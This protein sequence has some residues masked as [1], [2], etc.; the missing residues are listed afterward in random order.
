MNKTESDLDFKLVTL[1]EKHKD[2]LKKYRELEK[3]LDNA[4]VLI[5]SQ[6]AEILKRDDS[7]IKLKEND[8]SLNF[9]MECLRKELKESKRKFYDPK[10]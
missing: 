5:N 7:I 2:L 10:R 6:K 8:K 9:Q 1:Q 4:I 3:C